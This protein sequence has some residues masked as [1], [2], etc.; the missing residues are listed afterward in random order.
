MTV[1]L[2]AI[3]ILAFLVFI[4]YNKTR[5]NF[6]I[7]LMYHSIDDKPGKEGIFVDEFE[8]LQ[9]GALSSFGH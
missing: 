3:V 4:I 1:I 6:A 5:K 8:E 9:I 7:C 2:I